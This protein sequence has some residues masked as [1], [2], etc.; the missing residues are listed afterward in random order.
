MN[1]EPDK[2]TVDELFKHFI[3]TLESLKA[4]GLLPAFKLQSESVKQLIAML[5]SPSSHEKVEEQA[6]LVNDLLGY[7]NKGLREKRNR[8]DLALEIEEKYILKRK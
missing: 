8:I 7:Y 4:N 5:E 6:V 2:N 3:G 1:Q